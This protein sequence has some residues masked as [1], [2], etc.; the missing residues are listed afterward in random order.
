MYG[1][2]DSTNT[3]VSSPKRSATLRPV[4]KL[5]VYMSERS[6]SF[7]QSAFIVVARTSP[8][9]FISMGAV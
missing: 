9:A 7:T 5:R 4:T 8:P 3:S 6:P 2:V 1:S